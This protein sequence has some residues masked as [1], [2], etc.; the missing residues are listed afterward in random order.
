V[1]IVGFGKVGKHMVEKTLNDP[2][3]SF[4]N[5]GLQALSFVDPM[6]LLGGRLS[7]SWRLCA[8]CFNLILCA[9]QTLYLVAASSI[10]PN[11]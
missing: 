1:G 8:T 6:V 9:N 3:L 4:C 7:W 10:P 5:A 2:R 11:C